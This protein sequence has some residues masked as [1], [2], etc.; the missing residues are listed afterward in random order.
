[1]R[2]SNVVNVDRHTLPEFRLIEAA[3]TISVAPIF[4]EGEIVL[5]VFPYPDRTAGV[6][7]K[8]I[9]IRISLT[10]L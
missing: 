7:P 8:Q 1:M 2:L 9:W 10:N 3:Q 6:S 5:F 4:V